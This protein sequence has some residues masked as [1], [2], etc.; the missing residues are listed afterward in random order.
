M[1]LYPTYPSAEFATL[2]ADLLVHYLDAPGAGAQPS[3]YRRTARRLLRWLGRV[4][5][6]SA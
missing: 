4:E 5:E 2:L 3:G 1:Y 6:A